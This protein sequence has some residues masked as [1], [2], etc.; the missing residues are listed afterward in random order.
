MTSGDTILHRAHRGARTW[1]RAVQRLGPAQLSL[2]FHYAAGRPFTSHGDR[3]HLAATIQWLCAAQDAA[4]GRGVAAAYSLSSGWDVPYPET[5]GYI[6]ATFLSCG[7]YLA[8]ASLAGRAQRIADWE[9]E[10]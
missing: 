3:E 1:V 4:G 10:I 8:D 6:L 5:S 2:G 9:I 7:D